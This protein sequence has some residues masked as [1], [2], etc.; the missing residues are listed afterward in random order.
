MH[1][2]TEV[3]QVSELKGPLPW[4][5]GVFGEINDPVDQVEGAEGQREEDARVLVDDAGASEH[6]VGGHGGAL[7]AVVGRLRTRELSVLSGALQ[8]ARRVHP[9][10]QDAGGVQMRLTEVRGQ[11]SK[12]EGGLT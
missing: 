6:V 1:K 12:K 2:D 9:L 4:L 8:T 10:L 3:S 11:R 7:G 5:H